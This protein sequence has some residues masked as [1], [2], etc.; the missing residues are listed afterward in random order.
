MTSPCLGSVG[1]WEHSENSSGPGCQRV[2]MAAGDRT[3]TVGQE[4]PSTALFS[5]DGCPGQVCVFL[6]LAYPE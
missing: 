1:L 6:D 4:I 5:E 2:G 3:E